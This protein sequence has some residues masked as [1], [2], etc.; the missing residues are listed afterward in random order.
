MLRTRSRS[1]AQGRTSRIISILAVVALLVS[2]GANS[3]FA[4]ESAH[5]RSTHA[6]AHAK[7]PHLGSAH[8]VHPLGTAGLFRAPKKGRELSRRSP[9]W[10][11]KQGVK[12]SRPTGSRGT[13]IR[14]GPVGKARHT[15]AGGHGKSATPDT[16]ATTT[17]PAGVFHSVP[18]YRATGG[19]FNVPSSGASDPYQVAVTGGSTGVPTSGVT[20]VAV[21]VTTY[22]SSAGSVALYP[23]GGATPTTGDV[24][25]G[26]AVTTTVL[27]VTGIDSA[28]T[29]A[30][31]NS[32]AG[33]HA[34]VTA[35]DIEG[36]YSPSSSTP[37]SGFVPVNGVL[38]LDTA[39]GF[40]EPGGTPTPLTAGTPIN[41]PVV[42][43][44]S[45]VPSN[46][47]SVLVN[48]EAQHVGVSGYLYACTS[49]ASLPAEPNLEVSHGNQSDTHAHDEQGEQ[50]QAE[51]GDADHH[52]NSQYVPQKTAHHP[53]FADGD[54][55]TTA[56]WPG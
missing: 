3:A 30:V 23:W 7:V 55:G 43:G 9:G 15:R 49:C 35:I 11:R 56:A 5:H 37:D 1:T 38:V 33:G 2:Y 29:I 31:Y 6:A 16:A 28:G 20:S 24:P 46:A 47:T 41:V 51:A 42:G 4:S 50:R 27:Q 48:V 10:A 8:G 45:E 52:Q 13:P 19:T 14:I 44:D 21:D 26:A 54:P 34:V 32:N 18:L 36:Y 40:G 39:V 17:T 22:S 12:Y 25:Y 53:A